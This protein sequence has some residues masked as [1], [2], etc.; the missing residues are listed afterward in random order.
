MMRWNILKRKMIIRISQGSW[1]TNHAWLFWLPPLM[2]FSAEQIVKSYRH[3]I[4]GFQQAP[5]TVSQGIVEENDELGLTYSILGWIHKLLND[6]IREVL[7][8]QP[9][10]NFPTMGSLINSLNSKC[11]IM[12]QKPVGKLYFGR[13]E[14][15]FLGTPY[16]SRC[17]PFELIMHI[18]M[19][20]KC[21][22]CDS[23]TRP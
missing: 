21:G 16:F 8:L 11:K 18:Y 5:V 10:G 22:W 20:H 14:D 23:S 2:G 17:L 9:P 3:G 12:F 15:I 4:F 6:H 19:H 1:K 7:T 13:S